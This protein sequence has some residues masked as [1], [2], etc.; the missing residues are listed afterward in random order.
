MVD[1]SKT[2]NK[3]A[4]VPVTRKTIETTISQYIALNQ[5]GLIP[6]ALLLARLAELNAQLDAL[7]QK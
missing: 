2:R 5:R 4:V 6:D 1:L 3:Q 7:P